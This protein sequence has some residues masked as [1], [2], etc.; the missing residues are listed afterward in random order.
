MPDRPTPLT[1]PDL[2]PD[3]R[4]WLDTA[5][6]RVA[7]DPHA[8]GA[9][10]PAAA[11]RCGKAVADQVRAALL[12]ALPLRGAALAAEVT[13]LYRHGDAAEQRAVLY[14]LPLLDAADPNFGDRALP[15]TREALRSN[16]T[17]LV[18][19]ALGP[20]AARHLDPDAFRQAV[21]KC[22]FCEIPLDR[23]SGLADRMDPELTRMLTD[24]A[25]ERIAAGRPVPTDITSLTGPTPQAPPRDERVSEG[26]A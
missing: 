10:F 14:A 18:E 6:A 26:A 7:S 20:Y 4:A 22:V 25:R 15:V 23:I 9:A 13:G 19:A 2:A 24:F 11:R 12:L 8:V 3:A 5:T 1:L 16:D 21:L 17:T